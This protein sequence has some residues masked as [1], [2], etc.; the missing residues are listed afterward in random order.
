MPAQEQDLASA[1]KARKGRKSAVTPPTKFYNTRKSARSSMTTTGNATPA[2]PEAPVTAPRRNKSKKTKTQATDPALANGNV[3]FAQVIQA[4]PNLVAALIE[5]GVAVAAPNGAVH[6]PGAAPS[7]TITNG[8]A[9]NAQANVPGAVVVAPQGNVPGAPVNVPAVPANVPDAPVNV[10]GAAP[11]ANV[12][13]AAPNANVPGAAPNAN[14]PGAAPNTNVPGAAPN[15]NVP[16]AAPNAPGSGATAVR[17]G[18]SSTT[19]SPGTSGTSTSATNLSGVNTPGSGGSSKSAGKRPLPPDSEL[20]DNG[21]SDEELDEAT[22]AAA[23]ADP[24]FFR[25]FKDF[26]EAV[27]KIILPEGDDDLDEQ[28]RQSD[29]A[30]MKRDICYE[31]YHVVRRAL[32][33]ADQTV[34]KAQQKKD[35]ILD[36]KKQCKKETRKQQRVST[37]ARERYGK[38]FVEYARQNHDSDDSLDYWDSEIEASSRASEGERLDPAQM[39][40]EDE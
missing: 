9:V 35:Q 24:S 8:P 18:A 29:M 22:L 28:K 23:A 39:M 2:E 13:G 3:A 27:H 25:G 31:Q 37:F 6:F 40:D 10:P 38:T 7:A 21:S 19:T 17:S 32:A 1:V 33:L 20:S 15:T 11:N 5:A 30:R 16:G 34:E 26:V 14:V 12:P 4:A 36:I